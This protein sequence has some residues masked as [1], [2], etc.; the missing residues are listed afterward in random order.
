M[1]DEVRPKVL[2]IHTKLIIVCRRVQA[3]KKRET[4]LSLYV[5]R[6]YLRSK[7]S[8]DVLFRSIMISLE[9]RVSTWQFL[10]NKVIKFGPCW[11]A[12]Y[13]WLVTYWQLTLSHEFRKWWVEYKNTGSYSRHSLHFSPL[14]LFS[15]SPLPPPLFAPATQAT[16]NYEAEHSNSCIFKCVMLWTKGAGFFVQIKSLKGNS[17]RKLSFHKD[18]YGNSAILYWLVK[19]FSHY[20]VVFTLFVILAWCQKL[21]W[22]WID[23]LYWLLYNIILFLFGEDMQWKTW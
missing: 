1:F 13:L 9:K 6:V 22:Q 20:F 23:I 10:V 5:C 8:K 16:S 3:V 4:A 14:S 19:G 18:M 17:K 11:K 12:P 2:C 15:P 7:N 21:V